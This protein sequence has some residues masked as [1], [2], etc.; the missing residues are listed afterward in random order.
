MLRQCVGE[1]TETEPGTGNAQEFAGLRKK[2]SKLWSLLRLA[3]ISICAATLCGF[4][5]SF[6][7]FLDLFSH[8]RIQYFLAISFLLGIFLSG[9]KFRIA[10]VCALCAAINLGCI[11]PYYSTNQPVAS[12]AQTILRVISFNVYQANTSYERVKQFILE[13]NADIVLLIEVNSTWIEALED[14]SSVYTY[15]KYEPCR[16]FFGIA[17]YCKQPP[18][19]CE[20]VYLGQSEVPSVAGVFDIAGKRFTLLGAHL[21]PPLGSA[22]TQLRSNQSEAIAT[23]LA[24]VPEP[25]ILIGDLNMSPWSSGFGK[26]LA[27]TG[28]TDTAKGRG[29][30]TTWPTEYIWLRIPIDFCL[31][32]KAVVVK[33]FKVGPD[34]GSDHFPLIVDFAAIE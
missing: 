3:G 4:G 11:L 17:I 26:L 23:Y 20:F 15:H 28:L 5:G 19:S 16:D 7:W 8:F 18:I 10:T 13:N 32:S 6:W 21:F 22:M 27:T 33:E 14:I 30:Q 25:K 29:I 9:K 12:H 1:Q 2:Q 31:V 34:I 24:S